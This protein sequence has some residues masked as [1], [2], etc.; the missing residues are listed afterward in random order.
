M[1]APPGI[2]SDT[3]GE[4]APPSP[5]SPPRPPQFSFRA[6]F[7]PTRR[8][9]AP[10]RPRLTKLSPA[11]DGGPSRLDGQAA[12]KP[13]KGKLRKT[14]SF[15]A[16]DE[17]PPEVDSHSLGPSS[18]PP[19]PPGS[20]TETLPARHPVATELLG[21][22]RNVLAESA[23]ARQAQAAA[24]HPLDAEP[25]LEAAFPPVPPAPL[26]PE[27]SKLDVLTVANPDPES[28]AQPAAPTD[29]PRPTSPSKDRPHG[30]NEAYYR[31]YPP[32]DPVVHPNGNDKS[33]GHRD[34]PV[35]GQPGQSYEA[36]Q[37]FG[38]QP[39]GLPPPQPPYTQG[40]MYQPYYPAYFPHAPASPRSP[41]SAQFSPLTNP[42]S[43]AGSPYLAPD[44]LVLRHAPAPI[45]PLRSHAM[46]ATSVQVELERTASTRAPEVNEHPPP[47]P[48]PGAVVRATEEEVVG[49]AGGGAHGSAKTLATERSVAATADAE[50]MAPKRMPSTTAAAKSAD[51]DPAE[52]GRI[53]RKARAKA[54]ADAERLKARGE[55]VDEATVGQYARAYEKAMIKAATSAAGPVEPKSKGPESPEQATDWTPGV[56]ADRQGEPTDVEVST[57]SDDI[58]N[59]P[60]P[61]VVQQPAVNASV[62]SKAPSNPPR[63]SG[64]TT[65]ALATVAGATSTPNALGLSV[66]LSADNR[67]AIRAK[68]HA[69]AVA[70]IKAA[71]GDVG[72]KGLVRA[73]TKRLEARMLEARLAAPASS[74]VDSPGAATRSEAGP[75]A[76]VGAEATQVSDGITAEAMKVIR[77]QAQKMAIRDIQKAGG[78]VNDKDALVK[79]MKDIEAKLLAARTPRDGTS[80][81][82]PA[83]ADQVSRPAEE[84]AP[85]IGTKELS[86]EE[87]KI[88]RAQAQK[89]AIKEMQR[90]GGDV[91]DKAAIMKPTCR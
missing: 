35:I 64:T 73:Q 83:A 62:P 71:G 74:P 21:M 44:G 22:L 13:D 20:Q 9:D 29:R 77:V 34:P 3:S 84:V 16:Q 28:A 41:R 15:F 85:G 24:E 38:Q 7:T 49:S 14:V 51:L 2:D 47:A 18:A 82:A 59:I 55:D 56:K 87:R 6:L 69:Q 61:V 25:K 31:G 78:D 63:E 67:A 17:V 8:L 36:L 46:D 32:P 53:K 19:D 42:F 30:L 11:A 12:V 23:A 76:R 39:N 50:V 89:M 60:G 10:A 66:D 37:R 45:S 70:K 43:P 27:P 48:K 54:L 40:P 33:D 79:R 72:D 86:E 1:Y 88:L 57:A 65:D 91:N 52:L 26:R 68:A 90:R 5:P 80:L 81:A 4:S 75:D 58:T